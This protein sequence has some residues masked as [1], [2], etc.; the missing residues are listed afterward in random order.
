MI[1]VTIDD[2]AFHE[3]LS[4]LGARMGDM[5]P[6]MD[7]IGNVLETR[8]R[9]RFATRTDPQGAP[10]ALWRPSTRENY[11]FPGSSAAAQLGPG[12]ARLLDRYGTMLD[13]LSYTADQ[14]SVLIGFAQ[15]YAAYHEW[16][17]RYMARRGMLMADPDAGTLGDDDEKAVLDILADWLGAAA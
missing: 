1:T 7:S 8:I 14:S 12:N 16:G 17:T 13:T 10:W 15:P 4:A 9:E 6:A 2:R 5:T 11:P 3:Y